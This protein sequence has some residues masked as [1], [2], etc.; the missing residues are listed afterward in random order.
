MT[1]AAG[2][3]RPATVLDRVAAR[4]FVTERIAPRAGE[5]DR[6]E[7]VPP[8]VLAEL[9]AAGMWG[10]VLPVDAG[11]TCVDRVTFGAIHEEVGRGCSSVR[12]LLTVHSMVAA[13]IH[14]WGT[15]GQREQWLPRLCTG[16]V[17]GAF[18]LTEPE[19]GSDT[20]AIS[21]RAVRRRGRWIL[22]GHKKWITGGQ[23]AGLFLVFAQ[24]ESGM[25]AFLV[26]RDAAGVEVVPIHGVLGTRG[27]MLAE[28]RMS[29]VDAGPDA[30][31]GPERFG[32]AIVMVDALDL[33]RYSVASGCVGIAQACLDLCAEYT[34]HRRVR[35]SALRDLPLIRAKVTDMVTG[36][37]AARLLC[38]RAGR[39][40]DA[41]DQ[42][43]I[44]ATWMAKY[45]AAKTAAA[46][47]VD[48]VQILGANGCSADYPAERLYRDAK[49]MEIIEGSTEIQRITIAEEAYRDR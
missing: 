47:A 45:F 14:R 5:F 22:D 16:E 31:V 8:D 1:I 28:I 32:S 38:E 13:A 3:S 15:A 4:R 25:A 36:T 43:A 29:D 42:A 37:Q 46:S 27:S 34:S 49:V 30:L 41:D 35:D 18:C 19:A 21:T 9:S 40:R 26:P 2:P 33:G 17:L 44:M 24:G 11:G 10:A 12:S 20:G 39:L 6:T 23:I 48:A 7:R